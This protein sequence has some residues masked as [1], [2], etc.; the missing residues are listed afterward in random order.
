MGFNFDK[1][2]DAASKQMK[3][4]IGDI[5]DQV[6][7]LL[8]DGTTNAPIKGSPWVCKCGNRVEAG[9]EFCS[10]CG[11][12]R[13]S[14]F[15]AYLDEQAKNE[16]HHTQKNL[17]EL[18]HEKT[19]MIEQIKRKDE[20]I[21]LLQNKIMSLSHNQE[22]LKE[23]NQKYKNIEEVLS[24]EIAKKTT[25]LAAL[26]KKYTDDLSAKSTEI[27]TL[28]EKYT[29]ELSQ[30][31]AELVTLKEKYTKK[32]SDKETEILNLKNKY[33]SEINELQKKV[34][35]LK[36]NTPNESKKVEQ[37]KNN[38]VI[39]QTKQ[40]NH[41]NK[42]MSRLD[43]QG[44]FIELFE[45]FLDRAYPI[46]MELDN[47]YDT[48]D[49]RGH[50]MKFFEDTAIDSSKNYDAYFQD[51]DL[52]RGIDLLKSSNDDKDKEALKCFEIASQRSIKPECS[53]NPEALARLGEMYE[54]N[55]G[56]EEKIS[57]EELLNCY[58]KASIYGS[59]RSSFRIFNIYKAN[60]DDRKVKGDETAAEDYIR[61]AKFFIQ[62][63]A[64]QNNYQD[65]SNII[66]S[67]KNTGKVSI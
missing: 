49:G 8:D 31:E 32:L 53:V 55:R 18:N 21:S 1:F 7:Q 25:E 34:D 38:T 52:K 12:S 35:N 24:G 54:N 57:D 39:S 5:K 48:E 27:N 30:K 43:E 65:E 47:M 60:A 2:I 41:S 37:L 14:M 22:Q 20:T 51:E 16:L 9:H 44:I 19:T 63:A 61:L 33:T 46:S 11:T 40:N 10:M 13:Q 59:G 26:N 66:E 29:K 23:E 6:N 17:I 67:Y 64:E 36:K 45:K 56:V 58:F 42:K 62:I 3:T 4:G 28:R 50:E 15:D